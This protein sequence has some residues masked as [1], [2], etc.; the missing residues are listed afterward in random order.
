MKENNGKIT[1]QISSLITYGRHGGTDSQAESYCNQRFKHQYPNEFSKTS[2]SETDH[3]SR[4]EEVKNSKTVINDFLTSKKIP[5][6]KID[7][8]MNLPVDY[9]TIKECWHKI[10]RD[11]YDKLGQKIRNSIIGPTA[12]LS[13]HDVF[14]LWKSIQNTN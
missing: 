12:T 11:L 3:P 4:K 9:A 2:R 8:K 7:R 14:F 10:K 6:P 1:N 5:Y 13:I